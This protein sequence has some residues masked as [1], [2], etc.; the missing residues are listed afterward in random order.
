MFFKS[1]YILT[2]ATLLFLVLHTTSCDSRNPAV[3]ENDGGTYSVY[4]AL[5]VD[6]NPNFVRIKNLT[7]P[8]LSESAKELDAEVI[9]ED[10]EIGTAT[11]LEDTMV[12]FAGNLIHNFIIAQLLIPDN[13]YKLTV[14]RSDGIFVESSLKTPA[15]TEVNLSIGSLSGNLPS[16][17]CKEDIIFTY[18]NVTRPESI[19][20]EVGFEYKGD[21][22]WSEIG[23]VAKL[24]FKEGQDVMEVRLSPFNLL[25][26]VFPDDHATAHGT[27]PRQAS[28]LV[29][30]HQLDS[31]LVRIRYT[32]YGPEWEKINP[33]NGPLDPI[34]SPDII[35]DGG[36]GFLG[37]YRKDS[38]EV[39]IDQ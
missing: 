24:Q 17:E 27:P 7:D 28:P 25:F 5:S 18:K 38:F 32:H 15:V 23:R 16:A 19:K 29:L 30:C 2:V 4:G 26:E 34:D 21:I 11:V 1:S 36:L 35:G 22:H 37:A 9:F 8:F 31:N 13:E 6:K 3:F 10:V 39:L 20:M 12:D 14:N 33:L